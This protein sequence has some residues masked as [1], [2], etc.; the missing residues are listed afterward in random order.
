MTGTRSRIPGLGR[1]ETHSLEHC[2]LALEGATLAQVCHCS[3]QVL[4]TSSFIYFTY[5]NFDEPV[6]LGMCIQVAIRAVFDL[7]H[8]LS[9]NFDEEPGCAGQRTLRGIEDNGVVQ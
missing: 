7:A 8:F 5:T 3:R 1:D 4:S 2:S 9:T 6:V